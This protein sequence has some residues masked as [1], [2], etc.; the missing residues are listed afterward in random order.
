MRI[1]SRLRSGIPFLSLS[2]NLLSLFLSSSV[3]SSSTLFRSCLNGPLLMISPRIRLRSQSK[4]KAELERNRHQAAI[5]RDIGLL[6]GVRRR[7]KRTTLG[8]EQKKCP[9][10]IGAEAIKARV[11]LPFHANVS[12]FPTLYYTLDFPCHRHRRVI[13]QGGGLVRSSFVP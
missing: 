13:M 1:V 4:R 8:I 3:S 5:N 7:K 9:S 12:S 10:I 6:F 2:L 11:L